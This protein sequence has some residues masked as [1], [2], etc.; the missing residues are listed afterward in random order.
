MGQWDLQ[1]GEDG[2]VNAVRF[3]VPDNDPEQRQTLASLKSRGTT[4]AASDAA[5]GQRIANVS[6]L[7]Q[8]YRDIGAYDDIT[9]GD[10]STAA[11]TPAQ[12]PPVPTCANGTAAPNAATNPGL[13]HDCSNL[14]AG[15]DELRG[16]AA[17]NWSVDTAI[18][19]WE[20]VT[21]S[22][23]PSRVTE[24]EL[25]S[26]SLSGSIPSELGRLFELTTLDLSMNSLT[27]ASRM[28]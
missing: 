6:G 16:T 28:S 20:G 17:L 1:M 23:T 4:A 25:S 19:S 9:P 26:E 24:M 13:V 11:F 22:G 21:T 7:T 2:T 5:A 10:G 18:T 14:L 27:G 15:K 12:P 8:Y 3:G